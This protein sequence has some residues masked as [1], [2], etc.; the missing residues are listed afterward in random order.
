MSK[1]W[2]VFSYELMSQLKRRGF[3]LGTLGLPIAVFVFMFLFNL[4]NG[5]AQP[6]PQQIIMQ[7]DFE[8]IQAAGL[9]DESG[10]FPPERVP[11]DLRERLLPYPSV[12][13]ARVGLQTG[14]IDVFYVVSADWRTTGDVTLHMPRLALDKFTSDPFE[15]LFYE[16]LASDLTPELR[17]RLRE[18][19]QYQIFNLS[20]ADLS[21]EAGSQN[22][23]Q[24]TDEDADFLLVYVFTIIFLIG[25]FVTSGYL[26]QSV[27][28]EKENKAIE[29]L[30]SSVTPTQLLAGK[31]FA[32]GVQGLLSV[33][34]WIGMGLLALNT[35]VQLPAFQMATALLNI[36]VPYERLP[37]MFVYFI[38]AYFTFAALYAAIGALSSSMR[39]GPQY[40]I[41]FTIPAVLPFYFFGVFLS[42]PNAPL[43]VILSILPITSPISM[44]IRLTIGNVP[45][46]ELA[47]SLLCLFLGLAAAIWLAARLFRFQS[48]LNGN[49]PK[50]RDIPKLLRG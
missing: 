19:A 36:R 22:P 15:Q 45:P 47:A 25:L 33:S 41:V 17:Q 11:E 42:T 21:P 32:Y 44:L 48:L 5:N 31:I 7:F 29:V 6:D 23:T 8:G 27:I 38:G 40:A 49:T 4:I 2:A 34:T 18:P 14:E 50:L 43:P 28:E 37:L 46:L 16:S 39:E 12:E 13:A 1:T 26:M 3:W 35:A 30:V 10:E 24:A 9:V 20:R